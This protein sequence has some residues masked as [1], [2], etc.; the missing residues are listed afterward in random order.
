[1]PL[2]ISK[3]PQSTRLEEQLARCGASN[4]RV[5]RVHH[6]QAAVAEAG[7]GG[8]YLRLGLEPLSL[9]ERLLDLAALRRR[10]LAALGLRFGPDGLNFANHLLA[11]FLDVHGTANLGWR[12]GFRA[13]QRRNDVR[14]AYRERPDLRLPSDASVSSPQSSATYHEGVRVE[15]ST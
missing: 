6:P 13:D 8:L 7:E 10:R 9:G 1:V 14:P 3:L 4:G 5:V 12:V 2:T 15:G 11:L